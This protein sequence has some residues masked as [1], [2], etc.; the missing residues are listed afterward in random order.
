MI[1]KWG[2]EWYEKRGMKKGGRNSMKNGDKCIRNGVTV[3]KRR[4]GLPF[5]IHFLSR[6]P[7][8]GQKNREKIKPQN[9]ENFGTKTG[10]ILV[11]ACLPTRL[12]LPNNVSRTPKHRKNC[13]PPNP[14]SRKPERQLFTWRNWMRKRTGKSWYK[15]GV[16]FCTTSGFKT[17]MI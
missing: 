4:V 10:K 2:P 5:R 1:K 15:F 11:P 14:H 17:E 16:N 3:L 6:W 12:T 9:G 7:T 8:G 13:K